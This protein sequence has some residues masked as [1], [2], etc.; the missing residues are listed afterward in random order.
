MKVLLARLHIDNFRFFQ[1]FEQKKCSVTL[2]TKIVTDK[3]YLE[4]LQRLEK[5]SRR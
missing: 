4:E 3:T 5:Q 2:K 1:M